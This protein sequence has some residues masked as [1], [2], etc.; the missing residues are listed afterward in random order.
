MMLIDRISSINP[1]NARKGNAPRRNVK[2][3]M[4]IKGLIINDNKTNDT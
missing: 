2:A 4:I 3:G 1:P